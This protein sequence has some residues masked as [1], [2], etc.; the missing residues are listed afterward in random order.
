MTIASQ[1]SRREA[2]CQTTQLHPAVAIGLDADLDAFFAFT[3]AYG[4]GT[5]AVVVDVRFNEGGED[6]FAHRIAARF[7]DMRRL[8]YTKVARP[9]YSPGAA[10]CVNVIPF[11]CLVP[12]VILLIA[13]YISSN[14]FLYCFPVH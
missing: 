13:T 7:A 6:A 1:E 12:T 4:S 8:A 11:Q 2:S 14:V 5:H 9:I 3:G 10:R